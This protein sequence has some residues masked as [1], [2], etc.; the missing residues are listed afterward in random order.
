M[1]QKV[2]KCP[3]C[4]N[5]VR[6][7]VV[8]SQT[9]KFA[10]S[11]AKKGGMKVALTAAGSVIPGFGN[12]AGF[13]AGAAIDHWYGDKINSSI[14]KVADTFSETE[15]YSFDCP[16]C[17]HGWETTYYVDTDNPVENAGDGN[18]EDVFQY[19]FQWC[20]D[21]MDEACTDV[22]KT[23]E[24]CVQIIS[25]GDQYQY[26]SPATASK[27]YFLASLCYLLYAK[28]HYF[29]R[30]VT[31]ELIN[32]SN[33]IDK[34]IYLYNNG[35]YHVF[36]HSICALTSSTPEVCIYE[37]LLR[38]DEIEK[39][40]S[41]ETLFKPEWVHSIYEECRY[42]SI[43]KATDIVNDLYEDDEALS[44]EL[45]IK[46]WRIASKMQNIH[47]KM[48]ADFYLYLFYIE[49]QTSSGKLST[50]CCKCL[51]DAYYT[52]GYSIKSV[53]VNNA[54][55]ET[56]LRVYVYFAES[57]IDGTNIYEP[58]DVSRGFKM[59]RRVAAMDECVAQ[60]EACRILSEKA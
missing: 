49:D 16:R 43:L 51:N 20:V 40:C 27:F 33:Y 53:D 42:L 41:G 37:G 39:Y 46:L 56:W 32:A 6:G 30:N 38:K 59:L 48:V 55:D 52:E 9:R 13:V 7:I 25:L 11:L 28:N 24:L 23:E 8:E 47:Y 26:L 35:E 36:Q 22:F 29:S 58:K 44:D 12:L 10:T 21:Y 17:S 45:S 1:K 2:E 3:Q 18:A 4:G 57:L 60:E 19:H 5:F 54:Y 31:D 15:T 50:R 34:A 14:D